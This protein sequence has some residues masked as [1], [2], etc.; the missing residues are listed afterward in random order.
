MSISPVARPKCSPSSPAYPLKLTEVRKRLGS[1]KE[2]ILDVKSSDEVSS[3]DAK[4]A[5]GEYGAKAG[6]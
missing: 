2:R 4:D 1:V 6:G 5:R 3:V